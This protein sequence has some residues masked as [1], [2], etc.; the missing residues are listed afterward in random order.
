MKK[1]ALLSFSFLFFVLAL[2]AQ[3]IARKDQVSSEER[4]IKTF[5]HLEIRGAFEVHLNQGDTEK[6]TVETDI[7]LMD[8]VYTKV[9]GNTLIIQLER[10]VRRAGA[11]RIYLTVTDLARID[12]KGA[13]KMYSETDLIFQD[14]DILADGGSV[15]DLDLFTKD[16][17][18]ET[19]GSVV[20][21]LRGEAE[22]FGVN[23]SGAGKIAAFN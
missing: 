5:S 18:V 1:V 12:L 14:L 21:R 15:V 4:P 6:L 11:I 9:H 23:L 16:L 22:N 3:L 2:N 20:F 17:A 19:N 8:D 13:V 7:T 10:G